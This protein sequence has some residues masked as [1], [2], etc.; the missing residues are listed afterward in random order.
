MLEGKLMVVFFSLS[1][2]LSVMSARYPSHTCCQPPFPLTHIVIDWILLYSECAM[3]SAHQ[4][5]FQTCLS[6]LA[7]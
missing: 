5:C 6:N 4:Q 3:F 1:V 2:S 7:Y